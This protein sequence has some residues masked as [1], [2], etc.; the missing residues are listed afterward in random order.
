MLS[1]FATSLEDLSPDDPYYQKGYAT[2]LS[3]LNMRD[4]HAYF[5]DNIHKYVSD[6]IGPWRLL[7]V[8]CGNGQFDLDL[9]DIISQ[10]F[11]LLDIE[12]VGLEPNRYRL[13]L[14]KRNISL[15]PSVSRYH[16]QLEQIDLDDYENRKNSEKFNLILCV[17]VLYYMYDCLESTFMRLINR[18]TVKGKLLAVHQS[19]SGIVQIVHA[20]GLEQKSPV[21]SCNTFHL[22]QAL[23]KL[24]SQMPSLH[25]NI[26]YLD[27]YVDISC[28]KNINSND[29]SERENALSLFSFFLNK[30]LTGIDRELVEMTA[31]ECILSLVAFRKAGNKDSCLMFQPIGIVSLELQS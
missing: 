2:Y 22:R 27:N 11:P 20:A 1:P 7:S 9:L 16:F 25:F 15:Y 5:V 10:R 31:I 26:I 18:L 8:G 21:Q 3:L 30:K 6:T 17:R 12:Y 14:F 19:P 23:E 29:E 24:V 4:M 28:L 13:D